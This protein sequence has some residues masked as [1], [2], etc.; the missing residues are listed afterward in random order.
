MVDVD[1][2]VSLGKGCKD[3]S[4]KSLTIV[5]IGSINENLE[6]ARVPVVGMNSP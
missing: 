4:V 5:R 3:R 2:H 1:H 6:E